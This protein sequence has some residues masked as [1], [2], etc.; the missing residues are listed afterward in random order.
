MVCP[1]YINTGM[2]DGVKTK[3]R[4]LLPILDES[5]VGDRIVDAVVHGDKLLTLPWI[6]RVVWLA[7]FLLPIGVMDAIA[8][9]LGI[10]STMDEFKGRGWEATD[11][12]K[13]KAH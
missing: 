5:Y 4:F 10:S 6:V 12:S 9:L 1:Y 11:P 3:A 7:R 13:F 2:F 8:D